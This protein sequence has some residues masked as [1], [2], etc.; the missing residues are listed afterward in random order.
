MADIT[1]VN[2]RG[3][4]KSILFINGNFKEYVRSF[5]ITW[6][7]WDDLPILEVKSFKLNDSGRPY[8]IGEY[9]A[10]MVEY[11][12]VHKLEILTRNEH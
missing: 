4:T 11:Y 2:Q 7:A 1:V 3:K 6:F 5:S 9:S 8:A 12:P 10:D